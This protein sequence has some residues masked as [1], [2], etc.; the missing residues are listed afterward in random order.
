MTPF[1]T[2]FQPHSSLHLWLQS[3]ITHNSL[4]QSQLCHFSPQHFSSGFYN[5]LPIHPLY[6]LSF[7]P[8]VTYF[9]LLQIPTCLVCNTVIQ[10]CVGIMSLTVSQAP[11]SMSVMSIPH[12]AIVCTIFTTCHEVHF[13]PTLVIMDAQFFFRCLY[14]LII[15]THSPCC[16]SNLVSGQ[17][18]CPYCPL[19]NPNTSIKLSA[20]TLS[21]IWHL[22]PY[23]LSLP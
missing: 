21:A 6:S 10:G 7:H 20:V 18:T 23:K 12:H 4:L 16:N 22:H 9:F 13:H 1:I 11:Q 2:V 8:N 19:S 14:F 17:A 15:F 3:S 5:A